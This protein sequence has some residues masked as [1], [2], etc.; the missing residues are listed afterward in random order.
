[1]ADSATITRIGGLLKNT[2][3]PQYV[4]EQQNK[5]AVTRKDFSKAPESARMGGDHYEFPARVAG[6]RAAVQPQASDDALA[7][8]SRQ[9]EQKFQVF[10]RMYTGV[11]RVFE[12]DI[13]NT[14]GNDRAFVN[15]LDDE[16][17]MMI[18]DFLKVQNIDTFMDGSGIRGTISSGTT[19]ATQT[20]LVSTAFGAFGSRYLQVGDFVDIYDSGLTTS[21]TGG[22]GVKVNS[23]TRS[24]S[25]GNATVVF[26]ASVATTTNDVVVVGGGKVNKSYIGLWSATNNDT[27][28]FQGLSRN[29]YPI[30]KSNVVDAAGNGL[31]ETYLQQLLSGIEINSGTQTPPTEFRTGQAQ[32]DAYAALGYAQKRFTDSSLDKGFQSLDFNGIPFKK[33]V[34]CPPAAIFALN[35]KFV[36]NGILKPLGW[37]DREGN[38]LKWD[39]GYAAWKAVAIE[40]GNFV[41]PRPNAIGRIQA[42]A[43][44][45][46]YQQ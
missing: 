43:V 11:I 13:Q 4:V 23:I 7:T 18:E 41:Y 38:M 5:A 45:N 37:M 12:K 15:H 16:V 19:S 22:N 30:L 46:F 32:F 6:A 8:A 3:G 24:A 36:Q 20:L 10:D 27:G 31:S 40:T 28:S 34:D 33:D 14:E 35:M 29:T 39:A 26:S 1:M 9:N 21:R 44:G 2:Y 17:N 25:G 42:L